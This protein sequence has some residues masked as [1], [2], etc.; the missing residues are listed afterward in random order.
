MGYFVF[1]FCSTLWRNENKNKNHMTDVSVF[2]YFDVKTTKH[3]LK[4]Q[5]PKK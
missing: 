5:M 4:C 1:I 3:F 2:Q